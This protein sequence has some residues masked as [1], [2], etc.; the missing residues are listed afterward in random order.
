VLP[1]HEEI[2][3]RIEQRRKR[4]PLMRIL[5]AIGGIE[6]KRQQYIAGKRFCEEVWKA[7]G[8]GALAPAWRSAADMPSMD[9]IKNPQAW[10]DRVSLQTPPKLTA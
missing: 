10:L 8:P 9:E 2:T 4:P 6:M 3:K 7:G 5:E 1:G